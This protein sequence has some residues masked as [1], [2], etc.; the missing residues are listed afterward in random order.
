[1]M[2][3]CSRLVFVRRKMVSF[4][5]LLLFGSLLILIAVFFKFTSN[6]LE[7]QYEEFRKTFEPIHKELDSPFHHHDI[8]VNGIHWHY[9][10]EGGKAADKADRG[11]RNEEN[12]SKSLEPVILFIHGFPEGWYTWS[13]ILPLIDQHYRCIAI[14]MKGFGRSD[15]EDENYNWE[16]IASQIKDFMV[17]GLGIDHFYVVS[18]DWGTLI[19]SI[20]VQN[21]PQHIDGFIRTQVD[22]ILPPNFSSDSLLSVA[23]FRP[24]FLLFQFQWFSNLLM[25]TFPGG[26]DRFLSNVYSSLTL[27][28]R[29]TRE[30]Q[31]FIYEFLRP[32]S[33]KVH[34]YLKRENWNFEKAIRDICEN[35]QP[36]P[37]LQLQGDSD[38]SQP[39]KLFEDVPKRCPSIEM[40]WIENASHFLTVDQPE[41]VAKD[42]NEFVKKHSKRL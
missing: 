26:I 18:H 33:E 34:R 22:L 20:L 1:M 17:S 31:Y 6:K 30:K 15:K 35:K 24:Q 37:I 19:G 23:R 39:A 10:D 41:A 21:H 3:V 5:L 8:I 12:D 42:I 25:Y 2:I 29:P 27:K 38:P 9:V 7:K 4:S 40:K 28:T 36:F 11:K 13:S 16:V 32:G 14:D